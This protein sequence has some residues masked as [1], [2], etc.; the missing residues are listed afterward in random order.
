[1]VTL[2]KLYPQDF[3]SKE[4]RDV[5]KDLCLYIFYVRT[6]DS[7]SNI[8]TLVELSKYGGDK[9]TYYVSYMFYWSLKQVIVLHVST[10][11]VER[12]FTTMKLVK[13][14]LCSCL[15]DDNLSDD[16]ICYVEK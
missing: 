9:E 11:T 16:V 13:T 3:D 6:H 5:D 14:F 7:F 4:S 15:N 2:A 8:A 12:C 10:A 1:L